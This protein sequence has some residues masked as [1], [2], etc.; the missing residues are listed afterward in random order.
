[1]RRVV[2]WIDYRDVS[3]G[4]VIDYGCRPRSLMFAVSGDPGDCDGTM[5][6]CA[7]KSGR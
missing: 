5:F 1:M 2:F 7:G 4:V 6:E 3:V